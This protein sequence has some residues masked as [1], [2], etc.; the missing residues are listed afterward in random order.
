MGFDLR[1]YGGDVAA[2]LDLDGGGDRLM[3]LTRVHCSSEEA[4][5]RLRA[6]SAPDLFPRA[7][8]PE[9]ALGGLYLYFSCWD[10]A[11]AIAQD[12]SSAEG[13]FWHGI[14]HRQEPDAWNAGYWFRRVGSHPIF[15]QLHETA[16][17]IVGPP[18]KIGA[19][20]D[21]FQFIEL[22]EHAR[23]GPGTELVRELMMVQRTEWQLLFG[24]C[25]GR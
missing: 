10:E 9:A 2:L 5:R 18:L 25:A 15:P 19:A 20:W 24:Y 4:R 23:G 21:P 7:R 22:C 12:L 17:A 8:A 6:L 3:P 16:A 13:S 11:H 14:I 1:L